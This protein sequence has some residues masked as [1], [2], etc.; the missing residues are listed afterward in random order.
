MAAVMSEVIDRRRG[1]IDGVPVEISALFDAWA[2]WLKDNPDGPSGWPG[3]EQSP[4]YRMMQSKLLGVASFGTAAPPSM[5][6]KLL[7]VDQGVARL[8]RRERRA[9]RA[10][11][12]QYRVVEDK[13]AFCGCDVTTFYRRLKRARIEVAD[14]VLRNLK[15]D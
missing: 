6:I 1:V 7:L 15:S 9:F 3:Q 2:K 11:Y 12:L 14:Y 8:K 4:A 10:F 5:P 13:A